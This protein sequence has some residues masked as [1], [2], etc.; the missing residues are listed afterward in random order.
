MK[1]LLVHKFWRKV[2]GAEVY[3]QD[4]AR[5]L[6]NHGHEIKIYTT[7]FDAEGSR[8]VYPRDKNVIF[9]ETADYLKGGYFSR[10]KNIPEV[11][12]SQKIKNILEMYWKI[13][14]PT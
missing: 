10:L 14:N 5:I 11:I 2:G 6:R 13:L 7:D 9:G 8:D 3:F 1:I 12:Y 4:V